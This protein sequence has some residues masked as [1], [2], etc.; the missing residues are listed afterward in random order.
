MARGEAK[1][2]VVMPFKDAAE[3]ISDCVFSL[4][5]Q[6][7]SDWELVAVNDHSDN[8]T[9]EIIQSI[10]KSDKRIKVVKN[11]GRGI[12][13]AINLGIKISGSSIIARMD[14]DDI[15][16]SDRLKT[17]FEF[18]FQNREYGVVSSLVNHVNVDGLKNINSI[19][20]SL[21]LAGAIGNA[22]DSV[23]YGYFFTDSYFKV[24]T[25]SIGNGYESLF[26]GSVVDMFQFPMFNWTWPSWLPFVGGE[27][28]VFFEPVFNIA[29]ASISIAIFLIIIN[30]KTFFSKN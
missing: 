26:H 27:D 23:F 4:Q 15:M 2:S 3:S 1:V 16:K 7:L 21:I 12:V 6:T 18:L 29:D 28:F 10:A 14:A 25:F 17:Q 5:N 19:V 22:I 8:S 20:L 24:A 9:L 11:N 30:Y 13:D